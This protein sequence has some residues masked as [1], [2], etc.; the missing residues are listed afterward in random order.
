[1]HARCGPAAAEFTWAAEP[2]SASHHPV[3]PSAPRQQTLAS[4]DVPLQHLFTVP[5]W[6]SKHSNLSAAQHEVERLVLVKYAEKAA[7]MPER[8]PAELNNGFFGFQADGDDEWIRV[9]DACLR[10]RSYGPQAAGA[11]ECEEEADNAP[12]AWPELRT[13][14]AWKEIKAAIH[15]SLSAYL[16]ATGVAVSRARCPTPHIS[17]MS[18]WELD[19]SGEPI[20][21]MWTAVHTDGVNHPAHDHPQSL[22]S[23]TF[24]VATPAGVRLLGLELGIHRPSA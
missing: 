23:G 8:G 19:S 24:Y 1:M 13:S 21:W 5:I 11:A 12:A 10:R 6:T 22:A 4:G 14:W 9:R 2:P 18:C 7:E 16:K 15:R 20:L 17:D 3:V